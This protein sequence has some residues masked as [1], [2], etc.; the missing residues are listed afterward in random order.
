MDG[1]GGGGGGHGLRDAYT[2]RAQG[3]MA[4]V[5][6]DDLHAPTNTE[7]KGRGTDHR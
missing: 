6:V 4:T 5:A 1:E 3:T 2:C 7:R